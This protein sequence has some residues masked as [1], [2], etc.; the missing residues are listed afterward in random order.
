MKI[1]IVG[2]GATALTLANLFGE[3]HEVTIIEND[4]EEAKNLADKTHALVIQGDG[5][6]IQVLKESNLTEQDAIVATADDKT[7]LMV[8]Q[9]AK[10]EGVPKVIAVVREPKNEEL[11][12]HLGI[13]SIVSSV[14]T[15]ITAIKR[16][17]YQVGDARILAQ[18]GEGEIQLVEL[19]VSEESP[20]L[21]KH[22]EIKNASIAVVYRNG[23]MIIPNK[24]LKIEAGDLLLIAAKTSDLPALK[25]LIDKK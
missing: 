2:G 22:A 5:G 4:P 18:L 10:T 20:L 17:L 1:L 25:D 7:N 13:T 16:L 21:G 19:V 6:D 15:N 24:K 14:G 12:T 11:F 3:D 9:I 23:E 8:A